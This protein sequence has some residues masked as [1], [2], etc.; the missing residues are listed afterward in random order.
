MSAPSRALEGAELERLRS[1]LVGLRKRWRR[2]ASRTGP[3][4]G[5]HSAQSAYSTSAD[6][7][8][9]V[10]GRFFPEART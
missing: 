4:T 1:E 5:P 3:V 2:I 9:R 7:L 10:I 6:E 8:D